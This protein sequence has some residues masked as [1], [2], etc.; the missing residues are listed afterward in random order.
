VAVHAEEEMVVQLVKRVRMSPSTTA[1]MG[2][3]FLVGGVVWASLA[4]STPRET[5][6]LVGAFW[7]G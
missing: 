3:V 6:N 5:S 4:P 1:L 7:I 2:I